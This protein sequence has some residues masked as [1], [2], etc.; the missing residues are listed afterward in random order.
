MFRSGTS[1]SEPG[2][3]L[4]G[5]HELRSVCA[6]LPLHFYL[7]RHLVLAFLHTPIFVGTFPRMNMFSID[8]NVAKFRSTRLFPNL[9]QSRIKG[10]R[11][12]AYSAARL[13]ELAYTRDTDIAPPSLQYPPNA[14]CTICHANDFTVD[15]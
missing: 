8:C 11:K 2:V 9:L 5:Y 6:S 7:Y 3:H 13:E 15:N 4:K 10:K 14:K 12:A 1:Q